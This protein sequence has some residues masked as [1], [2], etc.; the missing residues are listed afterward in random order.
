MWSDRESKVDIHTHTY[1]H[2]RTHTHAHTSNAVLSLLYCTMPMKFPARLCAKFCTSNSFSRGGSNLMGE[3]E[4]GAG[5]R[6]Q[7]GREGRQRVGRQS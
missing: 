5:R 2:A 3:G 7:E 1:T 4:G 6:L